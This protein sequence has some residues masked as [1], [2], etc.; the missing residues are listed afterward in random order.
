[1]PCVGL[2][3][4]LVIV[5]PNHDNTSVPEL[6]TELVDRRRVESELLEQKEIR[7]AALRRG[8]G[9]GTRHFGEVI[10]ILSG[11]EQVTVATTWCLDWKT[12]Q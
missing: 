12:L 11:P 7:I 6:G 3:V 1:M 2:G 5:V 8:R 10:D 4:G 9:R